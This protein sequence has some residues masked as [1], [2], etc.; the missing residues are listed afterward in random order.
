MQKSYNYCHVLQFTFVIVIEGA[1]FEMLC[2]KLVKRK[3]QGRGQQKE[4][5]L[6]DI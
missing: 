6:I 1:N 5:V 4:D 3:G 2:S